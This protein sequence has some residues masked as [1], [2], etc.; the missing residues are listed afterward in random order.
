MLLH[1]CRIRH[2][3]KSEERPMAS[4]GCFLLRVRTAHLPAIA[5]ILPFFRLCSA[6][7]KDNPGRTMEKVRR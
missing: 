2:P 1:R 4:I 6:Y 7:Q 3:K 5:G